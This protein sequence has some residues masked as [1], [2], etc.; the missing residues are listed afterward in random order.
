MSVK[1]QIVKIQ[2]EIDK[3]YESL[4]LQLN[5]DLEVNN[6]IEYNNELL[7]LKAF[8]FLD[9][10]KQQLTEAYICLAKIR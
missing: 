1:D 4:D 5:P 3:A 2:I 8:G 7:V 6:D 10:A 9:T